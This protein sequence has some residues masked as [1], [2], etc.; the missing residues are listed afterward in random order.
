M[1]VIVCCYNSAER[2]PETLKHLAAQQV[3]PNIP[4]EVIVVDNASTDNTH[5]AAT[6]EWQKYMVNAVGFKVV[7]Q[8]V[9]GLIY[10]RKMGFDAAK[11]E[12]LLFCDDD[13]WLNEHYLATAFEILVNDASIGAL[14][15]MGIAEAEQPALFNG[16]LIK[17]VVACGSQTWAQ[18][19]HWVYGAGALYRKSILN[20]LA[21]YGWEQITTGRKGASLVAGEDVEICLMIYLAGYKIVAN[22]RLIFKHFVPLKRQKNDYITKLQYALGYTNVLLYSYFSLTNKEHGT[23]EKVTHNWLISAAKSVIKHRVLSLLRIHTIY[24]TRPN[25]F[26][27][28]LGTLHSL[29]RNRNKVIRQHYHVKEVL[30]K[31][32]AEK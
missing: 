31:I 14:G 17:Q 16:D 20:K 29:L 5:S 27:T 10:A 11:Y 8:P 26:Q 7:K 30:A 28:Q 1:S 4:W 18:T 24:T 9:A 19:Q 12:Y 3:P 23:P 22:D 6:R 32:N 13:N 25:E 2:L 15:G 21:S